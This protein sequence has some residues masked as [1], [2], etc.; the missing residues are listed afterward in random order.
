MVASGRARQRVI[1]VATEF[2][3][4]G[5]G[6][7]EK[8]D[9]PWR[10]AEENGVIIFGNTW[11]WKG[12]DVCVWVCVWVGLWVLLAFRSDVIILLH[13]QR[14]ALLLK[15]LANILYSCVCHLPL[16][17]TAPLLGLVCSSTA[18]L[19]IWIGRQLCVPLRFLRRASKFHEFFFL[20]QRFAVVGSRKIEKAYR[21]HR[22][23]P[24]PLSKRPGERRLI[25]NPLMSCTRSAQRWTGNIS[26]VGIW[27]RALQKLEEIQT[28]TH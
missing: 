18:L 21:I 12:R 15:H 17:Y 28:Q 9:A 5:T 25:D 10:L 11:E 23:S 19:R 20:C 3:S 1:W 14:K 22:P 27:H 26:T 7:P 4:N 16:S 8:R 6:S 2:W 24:M 13:L